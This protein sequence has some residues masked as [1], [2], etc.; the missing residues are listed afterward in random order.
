MFPV[1]VD[2]RLHM[3]PAIVAAS[4]ASFIGPLLPY[5]V[6]SS[7]EA[8]KEAGKKFGDAVWTRATT[9]WGKLQPKVEATPSAKRL[10][11]ELQAALTTC[12]WQVHWNWSWRSY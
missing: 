8:A 3:E 6:K 7:E 10:S 4:V 12:A 2:W 1:Q 9:I 5:L 11:I